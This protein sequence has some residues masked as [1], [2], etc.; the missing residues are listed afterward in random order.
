[1]AGIGANTALRDAELLTIL[2]TDAARSAT[3]VLEAIN[4]YESMMRQY[5]ND[6]LALSRRN[7]ESASSGQVFQREAFRVLL[8][9]AQASPP[10]MRKTI[11]QSA[12]KDH[13]QQFM[14]T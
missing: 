11:G 9:L 10:I 8:R 4:Q 5:A 12:I 3:P 6:A 7:A 14:K 1:M 13:Q 2:L